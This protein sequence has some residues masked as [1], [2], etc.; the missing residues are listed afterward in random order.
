MSL[1][2]SSTV[3]SIPGLDYTYPANRVSLGL[4]RKI[5][6]N[7]GDTALRAE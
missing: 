3:D 5:G 1:V 7:E 2:H 6:K 4:P